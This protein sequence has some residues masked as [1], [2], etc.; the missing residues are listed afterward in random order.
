MSF[1][2]VTTAF[3][4]IGS[5]LSNLSVIEG[6]RVHINLDSDMKW[7]IEGSAEGEEIWT[8]SKFEENFPNGESFLTEAMILEILNEK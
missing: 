4:S 3:N 6:S 2:P 8:K 1:V 5:T 7:K